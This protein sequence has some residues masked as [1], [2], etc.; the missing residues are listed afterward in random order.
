M[1]LAGPLTPQG[2][3]WGPC[4]PTEIWAGVLFDTVAPDQSPIATQCPRWGTTSQCEG[5]DKTQPTYTIWRCGTTYS[6]NPEGHPLKHRVQPAREKEHGALTHPTTCAMPSDAMILH[7]A[8][9]RRCHQG[10]SQNKLGFS[11]VT[12]KRH[13]ATWVGTAQ[14]KHK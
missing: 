5:A 6:T 12:L 7:S 10:F 14:S 3:T 13:L 9:K 8:N 2:H 4:K 1:A 11:H